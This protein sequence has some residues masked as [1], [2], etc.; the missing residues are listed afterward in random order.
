MGFHD[1][2]MKG[3]RIGDEIHLGERE[4]KRE[5]MEQRTRLSVVGLVL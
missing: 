1:K 3:K 4:R 2:I 5:Q